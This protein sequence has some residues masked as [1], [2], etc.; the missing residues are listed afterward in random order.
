MINF[1]SLTVIA[2]LLWLFLTFATSP[3]VRALFGL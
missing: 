3:S 2:I 1:K